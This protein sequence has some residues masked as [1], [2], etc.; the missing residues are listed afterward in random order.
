MLAPQP[1]DDLDAW[2]KEIVEAGDFLN[3]QDW[4]R[5]LLEEQI[6]RIKDMRKWGIPF[7]MDDEGKL[8]RTLG[9]GHLKTGVLLFPS[10][11]LMEGVV[12]EMRRRQITVIERVMI[13]HLF[14]SDGCY[15]TS[16]RV[17]GA[18]GLN[19]R[20]GRPLLFKAGSIVLSSGQMTA[21]YGGGMCDNLTGDGVAM[22]YR[23]GAQLTGLE[24]CTTTNLST[25]Q[26]RFQATGLNALQ[27]AGAK[28]VNSIGETFM[29]KYDPVLKERAKT[30]YLALGCTKE[31]WEGRGPLY[32][33]MRHITDE[34]WYRLEIIVHKLTYMFEKAGFDRKRDLI[35]VTPTVQF[36]ASPSMWGG[37]R[38]DTTCATNVAGLFAAGSVTKCLAHGTYSVGGVNLAYCCVAGYRAGHSAGRSARAVKPGEDEQEQVKLAIQQL[39]EIA[40][41]DKGLKVDDVWE[42]VVALLAPSE[43]GLVKHARRLER[44]REELRNI[45]EQ[46]DRVIAGTPHEL[47]KAVEL[48]NYLM[49]A[50]L[51]IAASLERTESRGDHYREEFPYADNENWLKWLILQRVNGKLSPRLFTEPVPFERYPH[52]PA[53]RGR[54]PSRVQVVYPGGC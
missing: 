38:V 54:I 13:T 45:Q 3:D 27:G 35:E 17:I 26:R 9:R 44:A 23:L 50:D 16:G 33:D 4:V 10:F 22:G 14:T 8:I 11:K 53:T 30:I 48:K 2:A 49:D 41:R 46:G 39:N 6:D 21:R 19:I 32:F 43:I 52:Q 12:R 5:V 36:P 7:L 18:L 47:A 15:P 34:A 24:F 25:W 40:S 31:A 1:E 37:I 42:R 20:T 29:Q 28:L 51:A